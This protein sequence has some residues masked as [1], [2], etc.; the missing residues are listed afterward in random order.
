MELLSSISGKLI[1]IFGTADPLITLSERTAIKNALF[2]EDPSQE[3]F[4]YLEIDD[5]DHGF[6]CE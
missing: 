2:E 4:N 3:R 1:C 6:M 5:A